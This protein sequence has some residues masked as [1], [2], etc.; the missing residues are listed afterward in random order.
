MSDAPDSA[1]FRA[2]AGFLAEQ[3]VPLVTI[4]RGGIRMEHRA[5][6]T[7]LPAELEALARDGGEL[8]IPQL[9]STIRFVGRDIRCECEDPAIT[10][11]ILKTLTSM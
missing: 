10:L 2:L 1:R 5:R 8:E 11:A 9:H 3:S 4:S 6:L 7:D